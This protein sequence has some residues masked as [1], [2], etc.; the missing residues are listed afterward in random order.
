M[1]QTRYLFFMLSLV[2]IPQQGQWNLETSLKMVSSLPYET[3]AIF[4]E[5]VASQEGA[6]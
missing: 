5:G 6:P 1:K 4:V 3:D 2:L